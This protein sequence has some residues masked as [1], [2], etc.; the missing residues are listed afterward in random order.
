MFNPQASRDQSSDYNSLSR[1]PCSHSASKSQNTTVALVQ[2]LSHARLSATPWTA[3]RQASLSFT[4]SQ[5]LRKPM[6]TEFMMPSH[7]L[8]LCRPLLLLPS[9]PASGHWDIQV[10]PER[11][12]GMQVSKHCFTVKI[13]VQ[14]IVRSYIC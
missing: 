11:C 6:S 13:D 4:I 2:V 9:F 10:Y 1:F 8:V 7:H 3:A 14:T 5:S 12:R